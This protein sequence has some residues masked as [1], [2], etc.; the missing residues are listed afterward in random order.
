M[1]L[2]F[3]S[4]LHR[5]TRQVSLHLQEPCA[6]LGLSTGEAHLVSYLRSY[7]PCPI[8]EL[9]RVFGTKPST[10]TSML[11]RLSDRGLVRREPHPEDRRSFLVELTPGGRDASV[12]IQR[13]VR[14]LEARIRARVGSKEI[15]GFQAVMSSIA[16]VTQIQVRPPH[17]EKK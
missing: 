4:P 5:A 3:L 13:V 1:A 7:G 14:S 6:E 15:A 8:T 12:A 16:E 10:L 17:K 9:S 2:T 11:D